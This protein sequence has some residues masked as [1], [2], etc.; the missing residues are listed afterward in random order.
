[1]K[2]KPKKTNSSDVNTATSL[3]LEADFEKRR[4][5]HLC[6]DLPCDVPEMFPILSVVIFHIGSEGSHDQLAH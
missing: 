1:M 6:V 4:R 3:A 5:A 2:K